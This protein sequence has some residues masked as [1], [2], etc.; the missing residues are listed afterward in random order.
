MEALGEALAESLSQSA[1]SSPPATRAWE[2][3]FR[4]VLFL[5][6]VLAH[7]FRRMLPPY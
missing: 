4:N 1:A 2:T 7:G 3:P 5:G 6:V